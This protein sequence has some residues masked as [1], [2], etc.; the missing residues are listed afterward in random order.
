MST[1]PPDTD[2]RSDHP[3]HHSGSYEYDEHIVLPVQE[4]FHRSTH[5]V[6]HIN[7]RSEMI[8]EHEKNESWDTSQT[9]KTS[10]SP[11]WPGSFPSCA[12]ATLTPAIIM[13]NQRTLYWSQRSSGIQSTRLHQLHQSLKRFWKACCNLIASWWCLGKLQSCHGWGLSGLT[14]SCLRNWFTVDV[15]L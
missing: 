15:D 12:C 1:V 3:G 13:D 6:S 14:S 5:N 10:A 9:Q 8:L 7:Q 11:I 4:V 2:Q